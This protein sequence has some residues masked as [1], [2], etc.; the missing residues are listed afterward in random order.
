MMD[1]ED[2]WLS[3]DKAFRKAN[4]NLSNALSGL[5]TGARRQERSKENTHEDMDISIQQVGENLLIRT[6]CSEF[7]YTQKF[8][9]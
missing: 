6:R 2:S 4:K 1:D 3:K 7:E 8:F 5:G 9:T